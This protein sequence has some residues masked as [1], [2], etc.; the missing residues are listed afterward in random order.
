MESTM[1]TMQVWHEIVENQSLERL[2]EVL[3]QDCVFYSPVVHTPQEGRDL[4]KLYL[5]GALMVFNDSFRYVKQVVTAEHAVLEFECNVDGILING[6][7]ILTF[8][9]EGKIEEFKVM[10][11]PLKAINLL[12]AKMR[13][14]LEQI[15]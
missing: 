9:A 3:A 14:M 2:D 8:N 15:K 7:D 5:S 13:D 6:V 11:R 1:N 10:V 12:H 4:T